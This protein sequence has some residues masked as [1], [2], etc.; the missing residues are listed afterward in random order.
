MEVQEKAL[1]NPVTP[2]GLRMP[3]SEES[4]PCRCSYA[5]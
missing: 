4:S 2:E 5:I 1:Y 3:L